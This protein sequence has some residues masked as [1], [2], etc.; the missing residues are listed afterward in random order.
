ML[1]TAHEMG[2]FEYPRT[3]NAGDVA[4]ALGITRSTFGEHLAAA[5]RKVLQT[6][7]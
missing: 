2:Y 1:E 3:S 6:L 7:G 5:Q 4:N